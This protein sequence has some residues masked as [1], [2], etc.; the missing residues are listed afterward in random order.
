MDLLEIERTAMHSE[1]LPS[2][3]NQA[4]QLIFLSFRC[5]YQSYR[6]GT[7]TREQAQNEKRELLKSFSE[8]SR[9]I[10]IYQDTCHMRVELGCVAKDMAVNG[11]PIC[12]KA[13]EIIDR[14]MK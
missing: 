11:C 9:W 6:A 4:E 8:T 7:I 5:L 12:N 14:R 3:L 1:P 13:I 10:E 2:S